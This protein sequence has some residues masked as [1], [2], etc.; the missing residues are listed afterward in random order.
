MSIHYEYHYG[1]APKEGE[2]PLG[3]HWLDRL[4]NSP[5]FLVDTDRIT[6]ECQARGF[7]WNGVML[8]EWWKAHDGKWFDHNGAVVCKADG[9]P[10]NTEKSLFWNAKEFDRIVYVDGKKAGEFHMRRW[11]DTGL[12]QFAQYGKGFKL[13]GRYSILMRAQSDESA[14]MGTWGPNYGQ[15]S[16]FHFGTH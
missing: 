4:L 14:A 11:S 5:K 12:R 6:S 7:I 15:S 10:L 1:P 8:N 9:V 3:K 16:G 2:D 13:N